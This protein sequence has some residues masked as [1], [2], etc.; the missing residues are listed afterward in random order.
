[1]SLKNSSKSLKEELKD[2][3]QF[4]YRELGQFHISPTSDESP[5][6]ISNTAHNGTPVINF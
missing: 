5:I 6:I 3:S 1:M 4:T 2:K